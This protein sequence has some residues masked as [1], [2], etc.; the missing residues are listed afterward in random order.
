MRWL[1]LLLASCPAA[2]HAQ[3]LVS[4]RPDRLSV[5]IYRAPDRSAG[6]AMELAWLNGYALITEHRT[7]TIPAGET[8]IRFEGVAEGIV[9]ESAIVTGLP[10]GVTEKNQDASLLSP[11]ALLAA[12]TERRVTV[13]RT[14]RATGKVSEQDAI[15]RSGPDGAVVM[16]T[17]EGYE[18]LRCGGLDE[19]LIYDQ[20]PV[21]LS[22]KPTLSVRTV[23]TQARQATV[24]LSY[25]AQGFDWQANYVAH[26][27]RDGRTI[28]LFAWVTLASGDSTSFPDADTQTVAGKINREDAG[29]GAHPQPA[30]LTLHC[31]PS[32]NTSSLA[33][34]RPSLSPPPPPPPPA[35]PMAMMM[36][37]ASADIVVTAAR[38]VSQEELGDLKL[39]RVPQPVTVAANSQK[40]VAMIDSRNVPVE[41]LYR[42]KLSAD[43]DAGD[44][45]MILRLRNRK[46]D[47]LGIPLPAGPAAVFQDSLG[48]PVLLG[49]GTVPDKAI[50]ERVDL[51]VAQATSIS[52]TTQSD[53]NG[54]DRRIT[55]T[56]ANAR[57][58]PVRFEAEI[59]PDP[60]RRISGLSGPTI[61]RDGKTIWQVT[62]PANSLMTLRY[63]IATRETD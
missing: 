34:F 7:I 27:A 8:T 32:E 10:D 61:Q 42:V 21:G 26:L 3:T 6:Q 44:V 60:E 43:G 49:E 16:Q 2:L 13:R 41:S 5:T 9:P 23:S 15:L 55:L 30:H 48:R 51:D 25:L 38:R 11:R 22:A 36:Q 14:D 31:W 12:S 24:T 29:K 46:E 47:R 19:K 62:L 1:L 18:A 57:P 56:A 59:T 28:D 50:G 20:V 35:A 4:D 37:E 53:D 45:R 58:E 33:G 63:R 17:R 39:Y 40:Q 52:A 54:R